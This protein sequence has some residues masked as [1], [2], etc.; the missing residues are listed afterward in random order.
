MTKQR[1]S[2]RLVKVPPQD[3]RL[4]TTTTS[5]QCL[6][7]PIPLMKKLTFQNSFSKRTQ[8]DE[9]MDGYTP[10]LTERNKSVSTEL[11]RRVLGFKNNS[12]NSVSI[13]QD[14]L[15]SLQDDNQLLIDEEF[16]DSIFNM[17]SSIIFRLPQFI[18]IDVFM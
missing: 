6:N 12:P 17:I 5:H 18:S 10:C 15:T 2:L 7:G 9:D 11:I 14:V 4:N 13:L 8:I 16:L 1:P 3:F